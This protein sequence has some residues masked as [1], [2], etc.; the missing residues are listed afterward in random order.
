[1]TDDDAGVCEKCGEPAWYTRYNLAIER[2][3]AMREAGLEPDVAERLCKDCWLAGVI[4]E[5]A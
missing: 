1:M 4:E 3:I 5:R 2:A